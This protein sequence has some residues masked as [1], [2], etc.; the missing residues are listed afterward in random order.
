M[1]S[2]AREVED[3]RFIPLRESSSEPETARREEQSRRLRVTVGI[4]GW[5]N[6]EDDITKP[7]RGLSD[8]TEVF[9]LRYEMDKLLALGSA[10][11][12]MASSYAWNTFKIE[13]L[14]RTV[15]ASVW[16]AL[17]PAYIINMATKV[18]NPFNLASNRSE[19][20]GE[21][22]A[23]ALI[24][25]VQGER[26]V[27]LVGYSLGARAIYTCLRSLAERKAFGLVD[28]VVLIGAPAPSDVPRWQKLRSVVA[29]QIF[30]VYTENDYIL[31][32][33]YRTHSLQLG[34][35]GLQPIKGVRGIQNL[36]LSSEVSGHLRYPELT[37]QI[38][39][40]CGFA[41][42]RGGD[43]PIERE[44]DLNVVGEAAPGT[45]TGTGAGA[46]DVGDLIEFG[47][48]AEPKSLAAPDSSAWLRE[49]SAGGSSGPTEATPMGTTV[50]RQ[51][52]DLSDAPPLPPRQTLAS[53]I[54]VSSAGPSSSVA[55]SSRASTT[56]TT[57]STSA[58]EPARNAASSSSST[59]SL[60]IPIREIPRDQSQQHLAIVEPKS[61][62]GD[63]VVPV[64][65]PCV[66]DGVR[67]PLGDSFA[68]TLEVHDGASDDEGIRM[69]SYDSD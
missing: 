25:K 53:D 66:A 61:L 49:L 11:K 59:R 50:V 69:V 9:A 16:A 44:D 48:P 27:T 52:T 31:G 2:Y 60:E 46:G 41:N 54:T 56:L 1:D 37:S 3:F 6:S 62:A 8:D 64:A 5:L 45:G 23:D 14:R 15:L 21:V 67:N 55:T 65:R 68:A 20:A 10:L 12:G 47:G 58:D 18:D 43:R 13:L 22:L 63:V 29:G 51:G 19:K 57:P 26:P 36:D 39:A 24:N 34:V 28:T 4:N 40:R 38:L 35:A 32:F 17:W 30:N 33:L 42:V 7:W